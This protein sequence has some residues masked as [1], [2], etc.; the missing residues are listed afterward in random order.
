MREVKAH[1]WGKHSA[2]RPVKAH[3]WVVVKLLPWMR[4]PLCGRSHRQADS[5]IPA[6]MKRGELCE[7]C[8]C[9]LRGLVK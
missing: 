9:V 4:R 3:Y 2:G 1:G 6:T 7:H 5:I 8:R